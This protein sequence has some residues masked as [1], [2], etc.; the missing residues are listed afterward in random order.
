MG[1]WTTKVFFGCLIGAIGSWC[2][3]DDSEVLLPSVAGQGVAL[4]ITERPSGFSDQDLLQV[5]VGN[6]ADCCVGKNP[7]AGEYALSGNL[8][9]FNPSFQFL[10]DQA[11]TVQTWTGETVE[12]SIERPEPLPEPEV[13]AIYPNGGRIPENT[14]RFYIEFSVPM[15]PHRAEEFIELVDASGKVD[16][17]AFMSFKQELWSPD[18]TRLTLLMDPGRIKRGVGQ[19]LALGPALLED[20]SYSLVVR[21]G[22][23]SADGR[24]RVPEFTNRFT[25]SEPLRS[26]PDVDNWV[27]NSPSVGSVEPVEIAFDRQ[28]D[29]FQIS[30]SVWLEDGLGNRVA[31]VATLTDSQ[32]VWRFVPADPWQSEGFDVV[33]DARLEDVAGNNFREVL[34]HELGAELRDID[35]IRVPLDLSNS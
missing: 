18:R 29:Q 23:P 1:G 11:Y 35:F 3:A 19:N 17:D 30:G 7:I 13:V 6:E 12:F 5:F 21:E 31:G 26:L 2:A 8:L 28:F 22:W 20:E 27:L 34:D 24:A 14:L 9:N 32:T 4:Q 25:V 15:M 33:V 16:T 10:V